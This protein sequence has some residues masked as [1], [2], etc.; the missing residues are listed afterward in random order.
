MGKLS[1]VLGLSDKRPGAVHTIAE[2]A[3]VPVDRLKNYL[4][5]D[6]LPPA[7]DLEKLCNAASVTETKVRLALG[8]ID[9]SLAERLAEKYS[10]IADLL[11][12]DARTTPTE[13]R[14]IPAPDYE[15][16][17]GKLF[18]GDCIEIMHSMPTESVDMVF[19]DPPF[20]LRKLYPSGIDDD[21]KEGK[22]LDWTEQW[23]AAAER[24]LRPG[25][26]MFVWNLPKWNAH[27][28][29]YLN[30]TMSF[31]HWIAV[32]IK[33]SLPISNRLYP[34][35]Y[36]LLYYTKGTPKTFHPDRLPMEI[37][38]HC[39]GDL[40]DYGGYKDKM[41]PKGVNLSDVWFD[42][43][44]VRH[45]KYKWRKEANELSIRLMDRVVE[46]GSDPGDVV[47]D[48]FSGSGTTLVAS[49]LKKRHWIGI[50]IGPLDGIVERLENT[51][52]ERAHLR[53]IRNEYNRLFTETSRRERE[54]LGLWTCESVR[55]K[56]PYVPDQAT[57]QLDSPPSSCG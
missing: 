52:N 40:R 38:P 31:R 16:R 29:S 23:L 4:S 13:N 3:G 12:V 46:I 21:L 39:Y 35:H 56:G 8:R 25:G 45:A 43:P 33:Y 2:S 17:F 41:N 34:S 44:P 11:E 54:K 55:P 24:L 28:A 19:A 47:L 37:C 18:Q 49:E 14:K 6:L 1:K 32:D 30:Q 42:I 50:E 10:E 9:R 20:N 51:D 15:T 53:R 22:Y 57:F 48:P 27:I 7:P 5:H 36:S 26:A